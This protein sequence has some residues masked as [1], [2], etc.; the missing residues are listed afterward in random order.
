MQSIHLIPWPRYLVSLK[1]RSG[2]NGGAALGGGGP[3]VQYARKNRTPCCK[4]KR[5]AKAPSP[6]STVLKA[7]VTSCGL[8]T[9]WHGG[10]D[11]CSLQ[12]GCFARPWTNVHGV[13]EYVFTQA[14]LAGHRHRT[15]SNRKGEAVVELCLIDGMGMA[16]RCTGRGH[17][18]ARGAERF[19]LDVGLSARPHLA[20]SWG[21]VQRKRARGRV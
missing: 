19:M 6:S 13:D 21:L 4:G 14:S 2:K 10:S 20:Q 3:L 7:L 1:G 17:R 18:P 12:C 9:S 5:S 15:W 8:W 16:R 11:R